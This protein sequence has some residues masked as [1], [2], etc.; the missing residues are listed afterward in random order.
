MEDNNISQKS[1][2][3]KKSENAQKRNFQQNLDEILANL[4]NLCEKN[5]QNHENSQILSP[6]SISLYKK[7]TLLLHACCG[8]CS[9]Y[10]LEYLTKY[11][12]ITVFYYNPNIY[13]KEEYTRRSTELQELYKKF[14]PALEGNVKIIEKTYNPDVFKLCST[15]AF[16]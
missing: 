5:S 15:F 8:P 12:Q 13:P 7:P 3:L 16:L 10:V 6:A 4:A 14:P 2:K 1:Q 9:S 11:F